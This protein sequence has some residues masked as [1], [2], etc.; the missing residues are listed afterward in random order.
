MEPKIPTSEFCGGMEPKIPWMKTTGW[1]CACG[2]ARVRAALVVPQVAATSKL[3]AA[4]GWTHTNH[5]MVRDSPGKSAN[6]GPPGVAH[7]DAK[8]PW[9]NS[10]PK[11][12]VSQK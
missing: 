8:P 1:T 12:K 2:I 5:V 4:D 6:R 9:E 7:W 3:A 10:P 11:G